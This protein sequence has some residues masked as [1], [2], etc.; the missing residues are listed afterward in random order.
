VAH[1]SR[2]AYCRTKTAQK[3]YLKDRTIIGTY[4]VAIYSSKKNKR[5]TGLA[6]LLM[7]KTVIE[8]YHRKYFLRVS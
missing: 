7:T 2:E 5:K 4:T 6:E 3:R 8:E 1:Y